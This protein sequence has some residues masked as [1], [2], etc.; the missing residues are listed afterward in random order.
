M[1]NTATAEAV[2]RV[3]VR[4]DVPTVPLSE[5]LKNQGSWA[6]SLKLVVFYLVSV[7]I[8]FSVHALLKKT[9]QKLLACPAEKRSRMTA[10]TTVLAFALN[11]LGVAALIFMANSSDVQTRLA[12]VGFPLFLIVEAYAKLLRAEPQNRPS[13]WTGLIGSSGGMVL[14]SFFLLRGAPLH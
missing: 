13:H 1:R 8:F 3:A 14:A 10:L 5:L 4:G 7:A 11:F 2:S 12:M 6:V 9:S